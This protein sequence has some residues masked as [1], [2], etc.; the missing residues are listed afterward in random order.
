MMLL[1]RKTANEI[2]ED[3]DVILTDINN[4]TYNDA[5]D[6]YLKLWYRCYW[7]DIILHLIL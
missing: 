4:D 6:V 1:T 7:N 3:L 5:Y 2:F